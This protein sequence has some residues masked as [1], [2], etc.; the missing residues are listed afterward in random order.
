MARGSP[1]SHHAHIG[2]QRPARRGPGSLRNL[3]PHD[4]RRIRGAS[5]QG[6]DGAVRAH[7]Q[8]GDSQLASR[9]H[10]SALVARLF[11]AAAGHRR[12]NTAHATD[13]ICR[14][15]DR[16]SC[17][18]RALA[19]SRLP[20]VDP[21]WP[22]RHWQDAP[23]AG[24]G[25]AA[26][27][28]LPR[29]CVCGRAGACPRARPFGSRP[30][31]CLPSHFLRPRSARNANFALP[32]RQANAPGS[33]RLRTPDGDQQFYYP[34]AAGCARTKNRGHLARTLAATGRMD[35]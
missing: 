2:P 19:K 24:I 3:P 30:G 1:S 31:R 17:V 28:S 23:G 13:A 33:G 29:W 6:N 20:P 10:F 26:G 12:I 32:A 25:R 34:N 5:Q 8:P 14:A 22:R 7:S 21:G 16:I 15:G 9:V 18:G 11:R 4:R 35:F 27:P